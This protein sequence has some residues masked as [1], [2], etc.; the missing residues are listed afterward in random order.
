MRSGK[1]DL[2]CHNA[3]AAVVWRHG[4]GEQERGL[5]WLLTF[6]VCRRCWHAGLCDNLRATT[7]VSQ[8]APT[9][10]Q[11]NS[12]IALFPF[13]C[14]IEKRVYYGMLLLTAAAC[15]AVCGSLYLRFVYT[16]SQCR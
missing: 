7:P 12:I 2:I 4:P 16:Q 11:C 5:R 9:L 14:A 8:A 3:E 10:Q 6:Q 1:A 15:Q 13:R